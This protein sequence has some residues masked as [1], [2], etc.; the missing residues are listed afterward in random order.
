MGLGSGSHTYA[1]VPDW[2]RLPSGIRFGYTHGVVVDA[3]DNVYVHNQSKDAVVVFDRSGRFLGAWGE[4]FAA[5]AHGL[6]LSAEAAGEFLYLADPAR[7]LIAKA[8]LDGEIL[9]R[10]G[11]P[12]LPGVYDQPDAYRPTDVCVAPNGDFYVGDGYGQSWV[13]QY[14]RQGSYLRSFGGPGS[15]PGQLQCP[16]GLWVD[17]RAGTP[18]LLVADRGNHRLQA[19]T[20]DG[21]HLGF[22]HSELRLPC[23]MYQCGA[24][25]VVPDLHGRVTIL[26]PDDGVVCHLGDDPGVWERPGWPNVPHDQRVPGRFIAPHAAC[27]DSHGDLYVVEWIADGRLTKLQH[28][29]AV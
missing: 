19:F 17:T 4:E 2:G 5:G 22:I 13:H 8:T 14:D 29:P 12:P 25:L 28:T 11:P 1:L 7:H 15:A 20:L 21:H 10:L 3:Q 27:V 9:W 16:H 18:R 6:F 23:C 26:G 24:E